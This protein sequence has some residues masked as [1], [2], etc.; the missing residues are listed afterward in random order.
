MPKENIIK[1]HQIHDK[2]TGSPDVQVAL[3]TDRIKN[4]TEHLKENRKDNP[5]RRGLI[6]MVSKRKRLLKYI[7]NK[8][9]ERYRKL[10][11]E[12]GIRG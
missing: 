7:K 2:D 1:E 11:K 5:S 12:L 3:L 4:L 9:I 10:I 8:D 6:I